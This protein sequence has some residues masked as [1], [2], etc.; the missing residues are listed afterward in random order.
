[1]RCFELNQFLQLVAAHPQHGVG[2]PLAAFL[3]SDAAVFARARAE[4]AGTAPHDV[5]APGSSLKSAADTLGAFASGVWHGLTALPAQVARAAT[6]PP[7]EIDP[8]F[9]EAQGRVRALRLAC[10]ACAA[11]AR[12]RADETRNSDDGSHS[13]AR[14][15]VRHLLTHAYHT[16]CSVFHY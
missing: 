5:D 11:G 7:A 3:S 4:E 2:E 6:A 10:A 8:W 16:S 15:M 14:G 13:G 9:N 12:Q 1:M